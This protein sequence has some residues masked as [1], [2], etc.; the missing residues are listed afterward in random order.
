[1]VLSALGSDVLDLHRRA[2]GSITERLIQAR[3]VK[4]TRTAVASADVVLTDSNALAETIRQTVPGTAI[5]IVRFGVELD[6]LPPASARSR[7]RRRLGID[8]SAFVL[9]SSRL[10]RPRYNIET[11][12]RALPLVRRRLHNAILILKEL[13]R[14][15]DPAYRRRCLGLVDDLGLRDAVRIVGELDRAEVLE[16]QSAADVYISVPD[17]D[18]TSVS[19]LEAMAGGLAVVASEV[20]GIDPTILRHNFTAALIRTVDADSLASEVISLGSQPEFRRDLV[21][22]ARKIVRRYGD[23][24]RELDRAVLLYD[25]LLR[26]ASRE[27]RAC[28][29]VDDTHR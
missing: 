29:R 27:R 23:F 13:E 5:R 24:D 12:I 19:V 8:E 1:L 25:E 15:S 3:R 16:L 18:G 11:I 26:P 22:R 14:F 21:A 28:L 17:T 7:W 20:P 6:S 2:E 4:V 9:L 10:V